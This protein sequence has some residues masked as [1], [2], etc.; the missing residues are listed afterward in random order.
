MSFSGAVLIAA[1]TVCVHW[2]NPFV[3]VLYF[4]FNRDIELACDENVVHRLG[5]ESR[6]SYAR[7]LINMEAAKSGLAPF[8]NHF[9]R[10]AIEERITA[11]TAAI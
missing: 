8:C 7:I 9:S 5:Q 4:L 6:S 11:I 2:F 1:L 3:W 10:T